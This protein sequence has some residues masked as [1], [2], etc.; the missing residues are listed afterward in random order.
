MKN[1]VTLSLYTNIIEGVTKGKKVRWPAAKHFYLVFS[2]LN[3]AQF[4]ETL[5]L[6]IALKLQSPKNDNSTVTW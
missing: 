3:L 4:L 6:N 2:F 5:S 1:I